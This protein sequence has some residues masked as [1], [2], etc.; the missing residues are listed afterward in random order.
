MINKGLTKYLKLGEKLGINNGYKTSIRNHWYIIPSLRTSE[1]LF[2]RR[3]N[4]YPKLVLNKVKA[5]T[6]DTMHRVNLKNDYN[7]EAITAGFYNSLS[8]ALAEIHGRSYGGGV[9]ELMPSESGKILIPYSSDSKKLLPILDSMI[10]NKKP[11]DNILSFMDKEL[12]IK[13]VGLSKKEVEIANKIWKKLSSRR[14]ERG[15]SK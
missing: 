2:L 4:L 10:R 1:L 3:N 13:Y 14:L 15:R 11:I 5:Y 7:L 12:L 8:F 6:T 9:L